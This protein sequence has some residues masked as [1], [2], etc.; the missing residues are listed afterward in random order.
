MT[1]GGTNRYGERVEERVPSGNGAAC[2]AW[3][4]IGAAIRLSNDVTAALAVVLTL[5]GSARWWVA[6]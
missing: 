1:L 6:R 2:R 3:A 5:I 4:D